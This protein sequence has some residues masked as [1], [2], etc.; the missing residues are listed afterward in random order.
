MTQQEGCAH[1]RT[2][3][4]VRVDARETGPVQTVTVTCSECG[5]VVRAFA[6]PG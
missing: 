4:D 2:R 3:E 1:E 6:V 5:K